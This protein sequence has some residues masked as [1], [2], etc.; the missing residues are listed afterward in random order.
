MVYQAKY[1]LDWHNVADYL[2]DGKSAPALSTPIKLRLP[3][4]FPPS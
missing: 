3:L 1:P 2:V 4:V